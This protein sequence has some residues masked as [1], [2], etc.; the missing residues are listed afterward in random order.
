MG[1]AVTPALA[2]AV[3]SAGGLGVLPLSWTSPE[4]IRAVV[5][6]TR[7]LTECPFGVN[8]GLAWDQRDRLAAAL[9]AGV[10]VVS[11]FWGDAG[12]LVGAA[13]DGGAIVF[14]TV[15]A[16]EEGRAPPPPGAPAIL[17]P[18]WGAGGGVWGNP[19]PLA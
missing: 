16:A 13:H 8:L 6:E 5:G 15:G 7:R 12:E 17:A 1:G 2:A 4:E 18:G 14:V 10:R 9:D 3:S 19:S 11:L